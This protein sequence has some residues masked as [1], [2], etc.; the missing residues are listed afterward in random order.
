[1]FVLEM[2]KR[3]LNVLARVTEAGPV[4][5]RIISC[6]QDVIIAISPVA[7]AV[8]IHYFV[9]IIYLVW[10]DELRLWASLSHRKHAAVIEGREFAS[11]GRCILR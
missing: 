8:P 6:Q 1:M 5:L 10:S 11:D 2:G 7:I 9:L 3:S 4:A